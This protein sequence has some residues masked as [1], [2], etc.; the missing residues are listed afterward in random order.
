VFSAPVV[1]EIVSGSTP[2]HALLDPRID[3]FLLMAYSL[4]LLAIRELA[5]RWRLP[6]AGVFIL[7]LAYGIW[8]EG[9]LAQTLLRFE[10]VPI[11]KFDGYIYLAGFNFSWAALI[12]PWHAFLAVVFPL[13][14]VAGLF[15]SCAQEGWLGK[16]VFALLTSIVIALAL[17]ISTFRKPHPQMLAC[18]LAM[19][20]L[21]FASYLLRG[22]K[23]GESRGNHQRAHPFMFGAA[24]Y[25]V[26]VLGAIVLA[27]N[28]APA[29]VYFTGVAACLAPLAALSGRYHF[30]CAPAAARLAAGTYF[31]ASLFTMVAGIGQ[32]S[33]ERS[34]TGAVLAGVFLCIA[35]TG[36][37]LQTSSGALRRRGL[38]RDG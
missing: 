19:A 22:R 34:L 12:V 25:P 16:R 31:G 18:L 14:L 30:Q 29:L 5:L 28:R 15:P 3:L 7:G 32:H 37:V 38:H 21:V 24:A 10:N 1:T 27:A 33:L 36:S 11:N 2:A 8:N 4:P 20:G 9:L 17:F 26:F 23:T 35:F 13:A 6:T